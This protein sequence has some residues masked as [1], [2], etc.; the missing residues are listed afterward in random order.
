MAS[1]VLFFWVHVHDP[2]KTL[3]P[4]ASQTRPRLAIDSISQVSEQ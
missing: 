3:V 2:W 4:T 1:I